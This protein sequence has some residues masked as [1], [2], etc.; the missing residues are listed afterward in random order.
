MD[1]LKMTA[2]CGLDCFNCV[3]YLA[4]E[5][6]EALTLLEKYN[7]LMGMPVEMMLCQ[8][9]RSQ[10]GIIKLHR[11]V[12]TRGEKDP[13]PAYQCTREKGLDFCYECPDFPCDVLHPYSDRADK[14]PHNTKVFNLCL[15]KKM[16]LKEWAERKAAAVR[17]VYF[18]KMWSL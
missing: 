6:E 14:V 15:I 3:F 7:K 11:T 2:P 12:S 8:G 1:Y 9:C 5:R 16:G 18:F 10:K 17:D 4:N 13:C